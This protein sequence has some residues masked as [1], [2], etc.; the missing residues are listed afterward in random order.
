MAKIGNDGTWKVICPVCGFYKYSDEL[1]RR[2]DGVMVCAEDW[3]PRH[4][5]E[6]FR[7]RTEHSAL[8][9]AYPEVTHPTVDTSGWG[10]IGLTDNR[11]TLLTPASV[12]AASD[13]DRYFG[14]HFGGSYFGTGYF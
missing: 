13:L 8:P 6:L 12:G 5:Q 2:W 4:P 9:F 14:L 7:A 1:K 11:G 3:E 10:G